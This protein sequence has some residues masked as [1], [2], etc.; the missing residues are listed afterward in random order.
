MCVAR[1]LIGRGEV[2]NWYGRGV[3]G[4]GARCLVPVEDTSACG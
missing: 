2:S 4:Q 3:Q 1:C